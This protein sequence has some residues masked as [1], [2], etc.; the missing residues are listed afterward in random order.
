MFG[1]LAWEN[2][3]AN[4]E[5]QKKQKTGQG[6]KRSLFPNNWIIGQQRM[7]PSGWLLGHAAYLSNFPV[8]TVPGF[9]LELFPG[10][11]H[12][13]IR[14]GYPIDPLQCFHFRVA[15]PICWG[16]LSIKQDLGKHT[17]HFIINKTFLKPVHD[18]PLCHQ[19]NLQCLF[20]ALGR[21]LNWF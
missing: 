17:K 20:V 10:F 1:V 13:V 5:C 2:T 3:T 15:L 8:I 11:H 7:S 9:L 14:K 6:K 18:F 12:L 16:I 19:H 21:L 4:T